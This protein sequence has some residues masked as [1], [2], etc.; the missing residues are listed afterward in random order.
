MA[1]FFDFRGV[2]HYDFP[3]TRHTVNKKYYVRV[4]RR[5]RKAIRLKRTELWANNRIVL[6]CTRSS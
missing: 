5:L 2:L 6:Y 3:P 1:V 4:M